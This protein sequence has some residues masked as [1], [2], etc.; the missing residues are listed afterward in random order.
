[1]KS[2][3]TNNK[4]NNNG[5]KLIQKG[6]IKEK[7]KKTGCIS[8]FLAVVIIMLVLLLAGMVLLGMSPMFNI[9]SIQVTGVKYCNGEDVIKASGVIKGTNGFKN[10]GGSLLHFLY[11]RYGQAEFDIISKFSYVRDVTV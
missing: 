6:S 4:R 10:I 7:R 8:R 2:A 1:M 5:K 3:C 9:S 11:L